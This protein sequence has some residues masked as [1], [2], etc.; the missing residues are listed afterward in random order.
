[1]KLLILILAAIITNK[2]NNTTDPRLKPYVELFERY[3]ALYG[4]EVKVDYPVKFGKLRDG[5]AGVCYNNIFA[6]GLLVEIDK[7]IFEFAD[8]AMKTSLLFHEMA[9]CSFTRGHES[10]KINGEYTSIMAPRLFW[11]REELFQDYIKELF[12]GNKT[13]IEEKLWN[14]N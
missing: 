14:L 5:A 8:K 9:H 3:S 10:G 6:G 1:M 2:V 12:T 11:I 7:E 13:D 4:R